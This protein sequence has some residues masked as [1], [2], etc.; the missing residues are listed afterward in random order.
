VGAPAG[1]RLLLG[2]WR[3]LDYDLSSVATVESLDMSGA[4]IGFKFHL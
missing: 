2:V 1:E 4:A 3:D